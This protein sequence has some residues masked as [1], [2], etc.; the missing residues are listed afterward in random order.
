MSDKDIT[1]YMLGIIHRDGQCENILLEYL[2]KKRPDIITLELSNYG[3]AFRERMGNFYKKRLEE[4]IKK[5][6][7][8]KKALLNRHIK[9]M[10]AFVSIPYEY[11]AAQAYIKRHGGAIYLIDLDIFSLIK[12]K[13]T[14]SLF[15][16]DNIRSLLNL[17]DKDE[18]AASAKTLARLYFE[19]GIMAFQYT[20][21]MRIR[22]I[23]MRDRILLLTRYHK[24]RRFLHICGWQHLCDP[25]NIYEPLNP[26]KVFIYDQALCV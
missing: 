25:Y 5:I 11:K 12:L 15:D 21:E 22:D 7:V 14:D 4:N 19:K 17:D 20:E 1:F 26:I 8:D 18:K 6:G 23:H 9:D 2:E 3:L 10:V 13:E 24:E 16:I